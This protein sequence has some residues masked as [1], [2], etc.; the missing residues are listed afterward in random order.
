MSK[1]ILWVI[2]L[3]SIALCPVLCY[4]LWHSLLPVQNADA[5]NSAVINNAVTLS[6]GVKDFGFVAHS[7]LPLEHSFSIKN[8]SSSAVPLK[9]KRIGCSCTVIQ[10]PSEVGPKQTISV[11]VKMTI[12]NREGTFSSYAIIGAGEQDLLVT[13]SYYGVPPVSI[14]P[15]PISATDQKRKDAILKD[16]TVVVPHISNSELDFK[17]VRVI[18]HDRVTIVKKQ[19]MIPESQTNKLPRTGFVYS[20]SIAPNK[21]QT[22]EEET[23][24]DAI[25]L[26]LVS[27]QGKTISKCVPVYIRYRHHSVLKSVNTL[28]LTR[29]NS[30]NP[31]RV[32]I[33]SYDQSKFEVSKFESNDS[34]L[35][36]EIDKD[37][38]SNCSATLLV[39]I[40]DK[41]P[42]SE[43]GAIDERL[44]RIHFKDPKLEPFEVRLLIVN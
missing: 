1:R 32:S 14:I 21:N 19:S 29:A 43:A 37:S 26:Q 30:V 42:T 6:E 5:G 35:I 10:L 38:S 27:S 9:L 28:T 8:E 15:T 34:R 24:P 41:S 3:S 2:A 31:V 39:R 33:R 25:T 13:L 20:L 36:V 16:V 17:L 40:S 7:T 44:L 11:P 18:P 23:I 4:S 22:I 12:D